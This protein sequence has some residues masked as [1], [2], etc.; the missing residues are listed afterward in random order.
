MQFDDDYA[1]ELRIDIK[2]ARSAVGR[3]NKAS[4]ELTAMG[5]TIFGGAHS[6]SVR[7][8][9]NSPGRVLADLDGS[10]DG[11]DGGGENWDDGSLN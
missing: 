5:L 6:G 3:L 1:E 7:C 8:M 9:S 10:F 11:G 2:K 4:R